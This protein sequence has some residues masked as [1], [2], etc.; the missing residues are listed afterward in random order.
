VDL[1]KSW[2]RHWVLI[3]GTGTAIYSSTNAVGRDGFEATGGLFGSTNQTNSTVATTTNYATRL[4]TLLINKGCGA[5]RNRV[6]LGQ[7]AAYVQQQWSAMHEEDTTCP[8]CGQQF[9]PSL[10]EEHEDKCVSRSYGGGMFD[11]LKPEPIVPS[12]A[13]INQ[14]TDANKKAEL[15]ELAAAERT[16]RTDHL[17]TRIENG[18]YTLRVEPKSAA[19]GET[20]MGLVLV[21]E[22]T[23][24]SC[25][26]K[27]QANELE[28]HRRW[29]CKWTTVNN[30]TT[31][32]GAVAHGLYYSVNRWKTANGERRAGRMLGFNEENAILEATWGQSGGDKIPWEL[33]PAEEWDPNTGKRVQRGSW[34]PVNG[35]YGSAGLPSDEFGGR[36]YY[37]VN[38]WK[39]ADGE[40]R[41][42]RMLGFN[43]E[44]AILEATW[45]QSGGDKIPWELLP[46][47]EW[48]PNTGREATWNPLKGSS[49]EAEGVI[50]P[51]DEDA[52]RPPPQ[53]VLRRTGLLAPSQ[54][55]TE[56]KKIVEGYRSKL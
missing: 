35:N 26:L 22:V 28:S 47:K 34:D 44:N 20:R 56:F 50:R 36:L 48:N 54:D 1:V 4:T 2:Q 52:T 11:Y 3:R 12:A 53:S 43:E 49:G 38:R 46:A 33:L 30:G 39:T 51:S 32:N 8:Y 15:V 19:T 24:N 16:K 21:K 5:E 37:I 14:E 29:D 17:Y 7:F 42:G 6:A 45:G 23:C 55:F 40:R 13:N 31:V 25:G 9:L 10:I 18:D 27:F 41:A